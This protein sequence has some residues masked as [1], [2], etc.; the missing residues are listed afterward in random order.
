MYEITHVFGDGLCQRQEGH[1]DDQVEC[2]VGGRGEGVAQAS[3]PQ[4]VNLRI[5]GPGHGSHAR[6]EEKQV[7]TKA[8]NH[9]PG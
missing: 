4:R 8:Q 9:N 2:P 7:G 1:G 3:G 5:N 6:G